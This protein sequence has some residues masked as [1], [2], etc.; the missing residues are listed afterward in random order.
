[1]T[2][3]EITEAENGIMKKIFALARNKD[4]KRWK[5]RQI[6]RANIKVW[7]LPVVYIKAFVIHSEIS[8]SGHNR[9]RYLPSA[10][11]RN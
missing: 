8:N 1:L 4:Q 7:N 2:Q 11:I 6:W 3:S 10:K 9:E 5:S